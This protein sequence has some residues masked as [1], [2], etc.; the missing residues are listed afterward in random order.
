MARRLQLEATYAASVSEVFVAL[1]MT[2]AFRRWAPA[3]EAVVMSLPRRGH[4][5]RYRTGEVLRAGRVVEVIRP[6]GVSLREVLHDPPCR[7]GLSLR[8]RVEPVA[9]GSSVR[10]QA[11]YRFNHAA[12][13][14]GRHWHRRLRLH[15][16]NQFAFI[17]ANLDRLRRDKT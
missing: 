6:V 3:D 9:D 5:Y 13:L 12:L 15:F 11:R 2:L 8:W 7:V 4:R 14:R 16:G 1:G 10:L 17:A